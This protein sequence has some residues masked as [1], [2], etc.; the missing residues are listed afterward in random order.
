MVRLDRQYRMCAGA[1]VVA[2]LLS[3]S[4]ANAQSVPDTVP[5]SYSAAEIFA[6]ALRDPTAA[7]EETE[8]SDFSALAYAQSRR[9]APA[10]V[11]W[12]PQPLPAVDGFNAKIDGYGGGANHI[13]SLYG[14]NGSLSIPLAQQWGAQIDG[15]VGSFDSSGTARGAGHVFWRDPSV[16]LLGAYGSY[17]HWN[18]IGFATIPRIGASFAR[19]A[20]E[21]EYYA[22]RWTFGGVAGYETVRVNAPVVAGLPGLF[23]VPNRFFDSI[24]ASY[25]VT[26]N[27]KLSIG[28]IYTIGRNGLDLGAEYG[29]AL[30]GGRMASLFAE[31]VIGERGNHIALAGL[32]I[33]FGQHD[34]T[35]IDRNRQDD[36]HQLNDH[37]IDLVPLLELRDQIRRSESD[38]ISFPTGTTTSGPIIAP[39][40]SSPGL[41]IS[42]GTPVVVPAS[43]SS[44][45]SGT[46]V[47]F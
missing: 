18:G 22:G 44:L 5:L 14:A 13:S 12:L 10:G 33:Y 3:V 1:A 27:L 20:A 9:S 11:Q 24:S 26:D 15:G 46:S 41:I 17:S 28:H 6:K 45:S 47:S 29:F 30:G 16:G 25:Y 19:Y 35:L 21:G 31:G 42:G 8:W 7:A 43:G 34:K 4:I 38:L 32:R 36:P 39:T 23:S 37:L 40:A 2:G